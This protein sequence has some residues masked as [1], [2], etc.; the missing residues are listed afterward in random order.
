MPREAYARASAIKIDNAGNTVVDID[1]QVTKAVLARIDALG[2]SVIESFPQSNGLRASLPIDRLEQL[3]AM[4]EVRFI[5]P[6]KGAAQMAAIIAEK[7]SR[8]PEER[9]IESQLLQVQREYRWNPHGAAARLRI[10][11]PIDSAGNTVVD[12][13]T[14]VTKAVLAR[15]DALGG[16]VINSFPQYDAIRASL[17]IDHLEQLAAMPEVRFIR[18]AEQPVLSKP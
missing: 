5:R 9:K 16:S 15:I 10:A 8:S 3:A 17:P 6:A 11:I 13:K 14:K 12:I 18:P 7:K 2:G 4:P 1:T